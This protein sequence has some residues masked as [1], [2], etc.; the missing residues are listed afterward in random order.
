[1]EGFIKG[2]LWEKMEKD[3]EKT[4]RPG[5]VNLMLNK[6]ERREGWME[7]TQAE[8]GALPGTSHGH[9]KCINI[10]AKTSP[11]APSFCH[12]SGYLPITVVK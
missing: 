4:G 1:M 7:E 11:Q 8:V 6:G 9:H 12:H 10:A 2:I 3:L 5:N